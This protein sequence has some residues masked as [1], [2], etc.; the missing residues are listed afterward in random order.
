MIRSLLPTDGSTQGVHTATPEM[1]PSHQG[2]SPPTR[3]C[4]TRRN[5]PPYRPLCR[6]STSRIMTKNK[7]KKN[8]TLKMGAMR[9]IP[10]PPGAN[11]PRLANQR[12]SREEGR[13]RNGDR[14]AFPASNHP[15]PP[16]MEVMMMKLSKTTSTQ[17]TLR[18]IA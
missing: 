15:P 12:R 2:T 11:H 8:K 9:G 17:T 13:G 16:I 7:T 14:P 1:S 4:K 18:R 6:V 5:S 3:G 10:S